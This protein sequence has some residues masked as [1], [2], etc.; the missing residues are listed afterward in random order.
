MDSDQ[1]FCDCGD[2]AAKQA[3]NTGDGWWLYSACRNFDELGCE[4]QDEAWPFAE[5][6]SVGMAE[7]EKLGFEEAGE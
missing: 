7:L 6:A 1:T 2:E 4:P 3:Y 5:D